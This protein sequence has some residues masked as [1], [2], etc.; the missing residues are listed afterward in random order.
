MFCFWTEFG[1]QAGWV[2]KISKR[3]VQA[4]GQGLDVEIREELQQKRFQRTMT[5]RYDLG[6]LQC[7]FHEE[8]DQ[9]LKTAKLKT[10]HLP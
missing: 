6:N 5:Q 10:S 4:H 1:A 9:Q 8:L 2:T 7:V 3:D